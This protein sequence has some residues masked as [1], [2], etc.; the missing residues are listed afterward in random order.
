MTASPTPP[1][2]STPA[3]ASPRPLPPLD[4]AELRACLPSPGAAHDDDAGFGA[5]ESA[6]GPLPLRAMQ[7][8]ARIVGLTSHLT[9]RQTFANPHDVPIEATY[10]FPLPDRAAATRFRMEVQGRVVIGRL[11]ERAQ[12]RATYDAALAAGQRAAITE[13]ERAGVFTVRVGNLMPGE[14]ATVELSLVGPLRWV[15]GEATFRFPLVVA[16]R[17]VPGAPLPGAPVGDGTS[18]DTDLAPDASRISPPV[19]LPGFPS[20]VRLSLEV[21]IEPGLAVDG[22]RSAL[23]ATVE[24][25]RGGARVVRL[26]P[27][28]RLDRDFVLRFAYGAGAS[29]GSSAQAA[30]DAPS[31]DAGRSDPGG[32]AS[33]AASPRARDVAGDGTWSLTLV[34]PAG[35]AARQRPRDVAIV[36]DRSGSMMGWKMVCARRAVAR[37]VD[38]LG[39]GDRFALLAFDN[40]IESYSSAR[41]AGGGSP[42][43]RGAGGDGAPALVPATDRERFRA[44]EWLAGIEARGGTVMAEPLARAAA[45]LA[46]APPAAQPATRDRVLVLV[47]DGQVADEDNLLR[48]LEAS[49]RG[50]RVFTLGVDRA[51]NAAFLER[52]ARVGQG[53]SELVETEDRLDEVMARVRR[54][55]GAPVLT[56]LRVHA[57][58]LDV[59]P[60]TQSPA[61]LPDLVAG[62]PVVVTGRFRGALG[63]R[64]R[65]TGARADGARFEEVLPL[66]PATDGEALASTWARARLRDLEDRFAA[67]APDPER[68]SQE[69]VATSLRFSVLSRFTAFVAVDERMVNVGGRLE[70]V[71]QPV[72]APDGW[73]SMR[74]EAQSYASAEGARSGAGAL[75]VGAPGGTPRPMRAPLAPPSPAAYA[76]SL[77]RA[78]SAAAGGPPSTASRAE[79]PRADAARGRRS[80]RDGRGERKGDLLEP[81][82]ALFSPVPSAAAPAQRAAPPAP[83]AEAETAAPGDALL[84]ALAALRPRVEALLMRLRALPGD[85]PDAVLRAALGELLGVLREL[86]DR[87]EDDL[88]P[89]V[90]ARLLSLVED[91]V[92]L[93]AAPSPG[94]RQA[95]PLATLRHEADH[96]LRVAVGLPQDPSDPGGTPSPE[97]AAHGA[98]RRA[99][100]K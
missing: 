52:L 82:V 71:V 30:L 36:L 77:G 79:A 74:E 81:A 45:L 75:P 25:E 26:H 87:H 51:V 39:D 50:T 3:D 72:E 8:R 57:E 15:D 83:D 44:T 60:E 97:A 9:L 61:R 88:D 35:L 84:P 37:I 64:L 1:A 55:I 31:L 73:A 24:E 78:P 96:L 21:A 38:S 68:L 16:P 20:P 66:A 34:P 53:F 41:A 90:H 69:I 5:L 28:E 65:V 89:T 70:K 7:V 2:V 86:V 19:L 29:V 42:G 58:G 18:A 59:L 48:R 33:G 94:P 67:G 47:T 46:A 63:G 76:P 22:L 40:A 98:R 6:R 23:H 17:Y 92:D 27:G 62:V 93:L 54:M 11:E 43:G 4:E 95:V 99:F 13:E 100:W 32:V 10:V 85:A 14:D 49:L 80:E 91:V 56:E 12:A